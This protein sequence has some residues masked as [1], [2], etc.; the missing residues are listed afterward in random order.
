MASAFVTQ[1]GQANGATCLEQA[2]SA[3]TLWVNTRA[4][5]NKIAAE[6]ATVLMEVAVTASKTT[7]V[8]GAMPARWGNT[9]MTAVCLAPLKKPVRRM[10]NAR[11][12]DSVNVM[13]CF[14][15]LHATNAKPEVSQSSA[16]IPAP[17]T[18]PALRW[19]GA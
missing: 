5:G 10:E 7:R 1:G 14:P 17:G 8:T 6:L 15:E 19:A 9:E 2:C 11:T 13:T 12:Q 4:R 18:V 3:M 16:K